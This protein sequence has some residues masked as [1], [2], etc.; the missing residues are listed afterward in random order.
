[1]DSRTWSFSDQIAKK[2]AQI[3]LLALD[4]D[5]I[6]T[7]GSIIYAESGFQV[8]RF[9]V[10]DGL[11]IKLM[12]LHGVETA[13]ISARGSMALEKRCQELGIKHVFQS[14]GDKLACLDELLVE[15]GLSYNQVCGVGDDWV[16]LPVLT[17]CG[18][19]VTVRDAATDMAKYVDYVTS[20]PGGKGAVREVCELILHSK[21]L[22]ETSI[23]A[24]LQP[25]K[26]IK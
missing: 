16:D 17:R 20:A 24:Y 5:G 23:K 22:L 1:M 15:L 26:I 3:R 8:Q 21:G 10:R 7:D 6:L 4:V 13:I 18:L 9:H 11:G 25:Q 12:A 14:V 2:A 19:S